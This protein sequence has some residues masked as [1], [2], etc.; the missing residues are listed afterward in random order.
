MIK[1]FKSKAL[2]ELWRAGET[3]KL[4][5]RLLDRILRRLDR[6]D[7]AVT[8]QEMDVAG[9]EFHALQGFR[10]KRYAVHVNGLVRQPGAQPLV[11]I[12]RRS[13]AKPTDPG[14]LLAKAPRDRRISGS[15][16]AYSSSSAGCSRR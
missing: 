10:P 8:P 5:I 11:W 16:K 15:A 3:K 4:D 13:L 9:F 7:V 2:A 1:T 6:L 14:M 12:A